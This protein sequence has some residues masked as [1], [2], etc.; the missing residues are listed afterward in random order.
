MMLL[1]PIDSDGGQ[2]FFSLIKLSFHISNQGTW[3]LGLSIQ[4]LLFPNISDSH[5]LI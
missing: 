2:P 4:G 5:L 3:F 1:P